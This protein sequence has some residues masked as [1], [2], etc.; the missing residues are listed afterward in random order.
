[1][2]E[3]EQYIAA[4]KDLPERGKRVRTPRGEGKVV[5]L[6]PLRQEVLVD[7]GESGVQRFDEQDIE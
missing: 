3:H 7:L 1:M 2:Y 6:N 5:R 4:K